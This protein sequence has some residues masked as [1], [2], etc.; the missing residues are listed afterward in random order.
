MIP[1]GWTY[2][3]GGLWGWM[4]PERVVTVSVHVYADGRV[5]P[6]AV[7]GTGSFAMAAQGLRQACR[8][9]EELLDYVARRMEWEAAR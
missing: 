5:S 7:I 6:P 2:H 9:M 8:A 4:S 3:G 1:A